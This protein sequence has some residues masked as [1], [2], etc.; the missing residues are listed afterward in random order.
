[1]RFI[2]MGLVVLLGMG[3]VQ[4]GAYAELV[5]GETRVLNLQ[6]EDDRTQTGQNEYT[7]IPNHDP[8][9]ILDR[10][11]SVAVFWVNRY[12]SG[13]EYGSTIYYWISGMHSTNGGSSWIVLDDP[14][15]SWR[16]SSSIYGATYES[17]GALPFGAITSNGDVFLVYTRY[18][19]FPYEHTQ[20]V[21][22]S[23]YYNS[24][25][26]AWSVPDEKV[27]NLNMYGELNGKVVDYG[28]GAIEL[29]VMN[30][31]S[32]GLDSFSRRSDNFG[33]TWN[34][35]VP[36]LVGDAPPVGWNPFILPAKNGVNGFVWENKSN[37]GDDTYSTNIYF[38]RIADN[39]KP[40]IAPT[41]IARIESPDLDFRNAIPI[42]GN[43]GETWLCIYHTS[44]RYWYQPKNIQGV[45]S[46]D[47]GTTWSAPFDL[48]LNDAGG[49]D[50]ELCVA[51][52]GNVWVVA[53][54]TNDDINGTSGDDTD[55][56]YMYSENNGVTWSEPN[57][58]ASYAEADR[59]SDERGIDVK[60]VGDGKFLAVWALVLIFFTPRSIFLM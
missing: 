25:Q 7:T 37:N 57:G 53:L 14:E 15:I 11:G 19:T 17:S 47:N 49:F 48:H 23:R 6:G 40:W 33:A 32:I 35:E 46:H 43:S 1:M 21:V 56:V 26:A 29:I 44:K 39:D 58:L 55:I 54:A 16:N 31:V 27:L 41:R 4:G 30:N 12:Y 51:A 3:F 8:I 42:L 9:V 45:I 36:L 59:T 2:F 22:G 10:N 5:V 13:D 20:N 50:A 34:D 52:E 60:Y 28:N 38:S 24:T 18:E